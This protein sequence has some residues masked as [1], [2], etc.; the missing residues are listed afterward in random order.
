MERLNVSRRATTQPARS[1]RNTGK[2]KAKAGLA[3]RLMAIGRDCAAHLTEPQK[4]AN[5]DD[6]LYD[7]RGLPK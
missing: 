3:E 2:V 1:A 7:E 5:P 6:L 4:S